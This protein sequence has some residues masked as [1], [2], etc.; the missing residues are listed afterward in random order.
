MP[1]RL[2]SKG[3]PSDICFIVLIIL[4]GAA[5]SFPIPRDKINIRIRESPKST[6]CGLSGFVDDTRV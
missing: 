5:L 1:D 3:Q 6:N 2:L 4:G